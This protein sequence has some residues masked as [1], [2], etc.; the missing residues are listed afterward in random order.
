MKY[1]VKRVAKCSREGIIVFPGSGNELTRITVAQTD[2][3][4]I[5]PVQVYDQDLA[6]AAY[7]AKTAL[8]RLES[9]QLPNSKQDPKNK[10]FHAFFQQ[11]HNTAKNASQEAIKGM[12]NM[13]QEAERL[14]SQMQN[15]GSNEQDSNIL[16]SI[17]S[18]PTSL[19]QT[20]AARTSDAQTTQGRVRTF[21]DSGKKGDNKGTMV[22]TTSEIKRAYGYQTKKESTE[23]S[24]IMR[25]NIQKLQQ[26]G[27]KLEELQEKTE[28]LESNAKGFAE[29][30]KKLAAQQ[31]STRR[32][33]Q[34]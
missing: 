7:A 1:V 20:S 22:R 6:A 2:Y 25:E 3:D 21:G 11:M 19:T 23:T 13:K 28:Q 32:W 15:L 16:E 33:W 12:K 17:I 29:A 27:E 5:P 18:S 9:V 24:E 26:R 31:S 34:I 8:D 4:P 10:G 30:A 14:A